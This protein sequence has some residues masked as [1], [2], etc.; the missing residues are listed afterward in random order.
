MTSQ[1]EAKSSEAADYGTQLARAS[2]KE[3]QLVAEIESQYRQLKS[4][5]D[6]TTKLESE[7]KVKYVD[8]KISLTP[9]IITVFSLLQKRNHH[10]ITWKK[11]QY[12]KSNHQV[13]FQANASIPAVTFCFFFCFRAE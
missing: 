1:M 2:S 9:G 7:K 10:K 13:P 12:I 6:A 8:G 3:K 5:N 11:H 4:V